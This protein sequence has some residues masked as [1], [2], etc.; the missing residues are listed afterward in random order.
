M[1]KIR[2]GSIVLA[3][4]LTLGAVLVFVGT[5][6]GLLAAKGQLN[7]EGLSRFHG[8]PVVGR[9]FPEPAP[10][11]ASTVAGASGG[12]KASVGQPER[13]GA[14]WSAGEIRRLMDEAQKFRDEY[15]SKME[16]LKTHEKR[17]EA[18]ELDLARKRGEIEAVK[19]AVKKA[20]EELRQARQ[21]LDKDKVVFLESE[22]KNLKR[23][24]K[25]YEAMPA[26]SAA[27]TMAAVEEDTVVKLM[28]L[29]SERSAGKVLA[30]LSPEV[31]GRITEKMRK[32]REAQT[33]GTP[34]TQS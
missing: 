13:L 10:A 31:A 20:W 29:M 12:P 23:M 14:G 4:A 11:D 33:A 24:A 2:K 6:A 16:G 26:D 27:A 22:R 30:A 28:F 17:L 8:L 15:R 19:K 5:L 32:M 9:Y 21:V 34:D 18:I 25:V 1:A 3:V 7:K